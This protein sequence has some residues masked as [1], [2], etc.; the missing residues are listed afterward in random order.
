M[1]KETTGLYLSGHPMDEYR[2]V[3]K[4]NSAV[5]IGAILSDFAQTGGAQR[6]HDGEKVCIAGVISAVKTKTT[7]N[8]TLMAD[9]SMEADTGAIEALAF[10]RV[11]DSCGSYITENYP[12]LME[13]R[14]SVRDEKAPQIMCDNV[15][16]LQTLG[17][18][19]QAQGAEKRLYLKIPGEEHPVYQRIKLLFQMFPGRER[20]IFYFE[21]SQ[22]R[23]QRDCLIDDLLLD[24]LREWLGADSV[25]VVCGGH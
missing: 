14:I 10:A 8:N 3:A 21:D 25:A 11:L 24:Q 20:V 23:K 6:Y 1:E 2:A 19:G 5:P 13:G 15:R 4:R 17:A 16:D 7:R 18:D 22:L 12:V 9:V